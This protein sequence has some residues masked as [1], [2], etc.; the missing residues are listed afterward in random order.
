MRV[1]LMPKP[2]LKKMISRRNW[3]EL[4]GASLATPLLG[5]ALGDDQP[6]DDE[7]PQ[8]QGHLIFSGGHQDLRDDSSGLFTFDFAARRVVRLDQRVQPGMRLSPDGRETAFV[9]LPR[10][11]VRQQPKTL[12]VL[13]VGSRAEPRRI[14]EDAELM[15]YCL[16]WSPD[17]KS[18]ISPHVQWTD[19]S[20][21]P[22]G[23]IWTNWRFAADGSGREKLPVPE[24]DVIL[25]QSPDGKRFVSKAVRRPG[26]P[27]ALDLYTMN[28]DGE[29][30]RRIVE[31]GAVGTPRFDSSGRWVAYTDG[32]EGRNW[33]SIVSV[34]GGEPRV[35]LR[36]DPIETVVTVC[37]SLD[38]RYLACAVLLAPRE[39][40]GKTLVGRSTLVA[41]VIEVVKADGSW[42][43]ALPVSVGS[44]INGLEWRPGPGP[45]P[46]ATSNP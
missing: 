2:I 38:S 43:R 15:P 44:I 13:R 22:Q 19:P 4:A 20:G 40:A 29:A 14:A 33:V 32:D 8:L 23:G 42:R 7:E 35:I 31:G 26:R 9:G 11:P 45:A 34:D 6:K 10:P 17:G 41:C 46:P 1:M 28:S 21:R 3:L 24:T 36:S 39:A 30:R 5:T 37:W 25:E 18:I 16:S 12:N 27:P